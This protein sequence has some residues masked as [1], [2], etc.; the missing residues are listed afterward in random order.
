[1]RPGEKL[2]EEKLMAEE[3]LTTTA[4]KQ[5]Y[6]GKPIAFDTD[7]FLDQLQVLMDSAYN[8]RRDIREIVK[9]MVRTYHPENISQPAEKGA[10]EAEWEKV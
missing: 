3:G 4:N 5:I 8:N 7:E 6:I 2:Y 1:M 10:E 9:K